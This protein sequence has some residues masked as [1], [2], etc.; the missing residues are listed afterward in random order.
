L[1]NNS[2][3]AHF[4]DDI[5]DLEMFKGLTI[6][7]VDDDHNI[8]FLISE[9]FESYGIKVITVDNA[10][11]A[12]KVIEQYKLDLLISDITMP[13]KSGYWLIRKIRTL[14]SPRKREIPAIAFTANTEAKADKEAIASGFQTYIQKPWI[15]QLITET[16]N[17]LKCLR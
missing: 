14:T 1:S 12:F 5:R 11:E 3:N 4:E 13:G 6:L 9:I 10:L 7:A 15:D 2:D 16:V 17:L 8:L